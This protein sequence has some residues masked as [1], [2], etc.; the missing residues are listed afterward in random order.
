MTGVSLINYA[1]RDLVSKTELELYI[2]ISISISKKDH[3]FPSEVISEIKKK[4][5]S[6]A[7]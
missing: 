7:W 4:E 1:T 2:S 5:C 3:I 6:G